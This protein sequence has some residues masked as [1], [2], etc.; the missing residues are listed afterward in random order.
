MM[1]VDTRNRWVYK[2][3]VTTPPCATFVYWNVVRDV[4]PISAKHYEQYL[5]QLER[6]HGLRQ[7]GNYREI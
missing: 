6:V 1:M 3:S 5:S 7:L 4:Y 2:G